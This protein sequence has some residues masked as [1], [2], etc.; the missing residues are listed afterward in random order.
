[1]RSTFPDML[2]LRLAGSPCQAQTFSEAQGNNR[3]PASPP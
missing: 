1:M 3:S 2:I